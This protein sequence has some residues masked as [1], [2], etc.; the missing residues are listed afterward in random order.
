[1]LPLKICCMLS[2][3]EAEMA[4]AA[5]AHAVGLV[6]DNMPNGPGLISDDLIT[7]IAAAIHRTHDD[8]IWTTLLTSRTDGAGLADHVAATGV[9][10]VQIVDRP[11]NGAYAKIRRDCPDVRIIQV[12]HVEDD[13]AL[14]EAEDAAAHADIILLDSGKPSAPEPTLG[15]TGDVHDWS[16][17]KRI[18]N[19]IDK[20]VL[21]AGGLHPGNV[22]EAIQAVRPW[23][24]DLCS[25][26]RDREAGYQLLPEKVRAFAEALKPHA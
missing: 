24:V 22:G 13:G 1:M 14:A 10:T 6:A 2:L 12:V 9:N 26:L 17:S 15:G 5:G 8:R 18:V 4:I 20:P 21:L 11:E 3:A 16:V 19:S 7:E 25:G 23:G